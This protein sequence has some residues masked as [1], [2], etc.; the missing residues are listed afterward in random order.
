MRDQ[1]QELL[2]LASRSG[3]TYADLRLGERQSQ[4]LILRN[5]MVQ[6]LTSGSDQ[7]IGI[8]VIVDGGWGF[9]STPSLEMQDWENT[10]RQAIAIAKAQR[11]QQVKGY[12]PYPA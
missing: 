1:L 7:G 3:A 10:V 9:A 6:S 4:P 8:R 5:G 11:Q 12:F 2:A